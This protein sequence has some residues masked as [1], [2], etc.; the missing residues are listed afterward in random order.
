M[1]IR[2]L[3]LGHIVAGCAILLL[4]CGDQTD[5]FDG[6]ASTA[7]GFLVVSSIPN[8]GETWVDRNQEVQVRFNSPIDVSTIA[9]NVRFR[10]TEDGSGQYSQTET[11]LTGEMITNTTTN[12][13][14]LT[15]KLAHPYAQDGAYKLTLLTGLKDQGGRNLRANTDVIF[16]IGDNNGGL[17]YGN[18]SQPGP[19]KLLSTNFMQTAGC[20]FIIQ[21]QFNEYLATTPYVWVEHD[22]LVGSAIPFFASMYPQLYGQYDLWRSDA[23]CVAG[24]DWINVEVRQAMDTSGQDI[25]GTPGGSHRAPTFG[26]Y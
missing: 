2:H 12:D 16:F 13:T 5:T 1:K 7:Q 15:V 6:Y 8:F 17:G 10:G 9:G 11:D 19:P 26:C 21:L 23:V 25:Q 18:F 22:P 3:N 20:C 24:M 14:V 4:G